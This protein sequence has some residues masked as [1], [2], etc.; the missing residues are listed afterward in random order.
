MTESPR[1]V[2]PAGPALNTVGDGLA[3]AE[4]LVTAVSAGERV[5]L[6][7]S[8]VERMTPSFA[9]AVV[10]TVYERV[11]AEVGK[12]AIQVR[13]ASQAV[14]HAWTKAEDRFCRGIRLSTQQPRSA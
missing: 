11:S 13:H 10:M 9:N 5:E 1:I 2:K 3:L 7:F 14:E 4:L 8:L 12:S 6:D